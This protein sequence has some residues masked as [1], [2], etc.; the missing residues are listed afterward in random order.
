MPAETISH[1]RLLEQLGAGGMGVVYKGLDLKLGRTVALK[2]LP[3]HLAKDRA[4]LDRFQREARSASALNHPGICTVFEIDE[5]DGHAFIAMELLEGT[6]LKDRFAAGRLGIDEVLDI[7]SQLAD[8]LHAAHSKGILHRDIK[9]ANIFIR[10]DG[11][12]KI[13]DF[14]LAKLGAVAEQLWDDD[15]TAAML[16]TPGTILGTAAY[17]SPEQVLAKPLDAR[18][19]LFSFG[20]VLYEMSTGERLFTG[21]PAAL[22]GAVLHQH[23]PPPSMRWQDIPSAFD[24]IVLKALE[25]DREV[26][27]Q[28]AAELRADLRRLRRD[29]DIARISSEISSSSIDRRGL[30]PPPSTTRW[31]KWI[32]PVAVLVVAGIIYVL[33]LIPRRSGQASATVTGNFTQLTEQQGLEAYPSLAPDGSSVVYAARMAGNWDIYLQRVDG[34]KM[35]NLTGDSADDDTQPAFSPDGERIAFRSDRNGGG[36]FLMGATGESVRRVSDFGYNPAWSPD[37]KSIVCATEPIDLPN[38][39]LSV[40]ALW[41]IDAA[42]GRKQRIFEGDAVQPSWSPHGHR[43]AYWM[44]S[45]SG[46]RDIWTI[47][48]QGGQPVPVTLDVR[49][50]WNPVWS[51]DGEYLY[52]S[53]DRGGSMNLWRLRIDERTGAVGG[54]PEPVT[55]PSS[56]SG[57]IS[58]ARNGT[59]IAYLAQLFVQNLSRIQ[60]DA[61]KER[62]AESA[63]RVSQSTRDLHF[64][65]VAPDGEWVAFSDDESICLIHPDGSG[66]RQLTGD[67]NKE[68]GPRWS[69]DGKRI[70][71]YSNRS[72]SYQI[73]TIKPDGDGLQQV[74]DQPNTSGLFHPVWSPDGRTITA[75][76]FEGTS[77][78]VDVSKAW[79]EQRPRTLPPLGTTGR[80]FVAWAWSATGRRLAGWQLSSDGASAGITVYDTTSRTYQ[81]LSDSGRHPIWLRDERRLLFADKRKL[82]LLKLESGTT[83]QLT[84]PFGFAEE[85]SLS[86][87]GR[88]IYFVEAVREGDVWLMEITSERRP[89]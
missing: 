80:S 84:M 58:F 76:S 41:V 49:W 4:A 29:T 19:D 3:D 57:Y 23:P 45:A 87:D 36:L 68:R 40:S 52:F 47:P 82:F 18:S 62:T 55:T 37:G 64:A 63:V 60:F 89:Q 78:I 24:Q 44:A 65:D 17:M 20:V 1:Y 85:F 77:H 79:S 21:P 38:N 46:Q 6:S 11:R 74:T 54:A 39:R 66:F 14:G 61:D 56:N 42:T 32:V 2:F 59:K 88:W 35:I 48:A 86:S 67:S 5:A 81:K 34:K 50:D 83:Q 27:Y 26:R 16:S 70:A 31:R 9:P 43:I 30:E 53:S 33:T 7:G 8:A 15:E 71:F 72:G 73:W 22:Y 51:P 12:V 10:T 69:P 13:L 75:S 25:K 28:T